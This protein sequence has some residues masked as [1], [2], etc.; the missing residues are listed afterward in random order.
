MNRKRIEQSGVKKKGCGV[1][2]GTETDRQRTK[3]AAQ[4][5]HHGSRFAGGLFICL[6]L[7]FLLIASELSAGCDADRERLVARAAGARL[8]DGTAAA[9]ADE[10]L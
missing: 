7:L 10:R 4:S 2:A 8:T 3:A 1:C 5:G 9:A 6:G